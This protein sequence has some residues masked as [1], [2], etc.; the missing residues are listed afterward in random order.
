MSLAIFLVTLAF[1][2]V[3]QSAIPFL[4]KRTIVF[5]VTIPEEYA[6]DPS[7]LSFRRRYSALVFIIGTLSL[8]ALLVWST[9][10]SV[11]ENQLVFTGLAIQSGLLLLSM[12]L[13]LYFHAKT[14]KLKQVN[15]WNSGLKQVRIA[16][17]QNHAKDSML[18]NF[19]YVLP[20]FVTIGL[21]VYTASQY[22]LLPDQIP[23]HWGPDGQPDAYSQ[24]SPFSSIALLLILFVMQVMM[25]GINVATKLSG[26]KLNVGKKKSSQLQQLAF[27]KYSSW[28]LLL[29]TILL[30]ILFGF[31]QLTTIDGAL[32]NETLMM[33]VPL[34]FLV[35]ILVSSAI[36]AFKVGQGGS[37]IVV[38][39]EENET[40]S[41]TDDDMD[42]HWKLG[43]FYVNK[44]DPSIFVEKRFGIGWSINFGNPIGYLVLFVPIIIIL[45]ISFFA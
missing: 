5:G 21:L 37:R 15:N 9:T 13:Y 14:M 8:I 17:L 35:L 4:L 20:M 28:F 16:D 29:I 39:V 31:L 26:I 38:S 22:S 11:S 25:L 42:D 34:G 41:A 30:T 18:P 3:I 44:Q 36:Y 23:M 45:L 33:A 19:M 12:A 7:I 27:R 24:K 2:I 10:T 6:M 32:Q 43:V 1:L 40:T